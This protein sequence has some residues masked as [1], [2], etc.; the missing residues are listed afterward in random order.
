MIS[1]GRKRLFFPPFEDGSLSLNGALSST[2]VRHPDGLLG[3]G[4]SE[5]KLT[6]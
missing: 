6:R 2:R 4:G 3:L 5:P 1:V